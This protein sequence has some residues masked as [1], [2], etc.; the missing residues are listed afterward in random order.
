MLIPINQIRQIYHTM[1]NMALE[2]ESR[3][4]TMYIFVTNDTDSLCASRV[5]TVSDHMTIIMDQ[6]GGSLA[7]LPPQML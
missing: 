6:V 5:F 7:N 2:K 3:G 1:L 4:C